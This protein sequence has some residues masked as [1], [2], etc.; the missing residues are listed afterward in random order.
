MSA[1]D[2]LVDD[3]EDV[4]FANGD[5][6]VGSSD[7]QHV[8]H[9]LKADKGHYRQW[10]LLGVGMLDYVNGAVEPEVIRQ[11]IRTNLRNDNYNV[12]QVIV[13]RDYEISID[14]QRIS[15]DI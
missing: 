15:N 14:A 11:T 4:V 10:P 6:L 13:T 3:N 12:R 8:K 5:F 7:Q 9:I 1:I 2:I